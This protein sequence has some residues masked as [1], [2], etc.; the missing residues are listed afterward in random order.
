MW[1]YNQKIENVF[2]KRLYVWSYVSYG[3]YP[4][5]NAQKTGNAICYT[6]SGS[7]DVPPITVRVLY[8]PLE[9]TQAL[10]VRTLYPRLENVLAHQQNQCYQHNST[11]HH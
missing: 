11:A 2:K 4:D 8:R 7:I 9:I 5:T 6:V 1:F 10:T 3:T